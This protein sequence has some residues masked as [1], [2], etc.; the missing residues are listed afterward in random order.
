MTPRLA[1]L[2]QTTVGQAVVVEQHDEVPGQIDSE[3]QHADSTMSGRLRCGR[4]LA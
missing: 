3:G 2:I 1:V 4:S